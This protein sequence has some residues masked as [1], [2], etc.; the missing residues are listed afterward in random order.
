M[1]SME[2]TYLEH[3]AVAAGNAAIGEVERLVSDALSNGLA[4][5][6][7]AETFA[8]ELSGQL[9]ALLS[10]AST[11]VRAAHSSAAPA[12]SFARIIEKQDVRLRELLLTAASAAR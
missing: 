7:L 8:S 11:H 4:N 3:R 12:G 1:N 5:G 2:L 10:Q 6:S 9:W